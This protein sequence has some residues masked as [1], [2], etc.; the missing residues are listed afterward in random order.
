MD[1]SGYGDNLVF[2][3]GLASAEPYYYISAQLNL[4][5]KSALNKVYYFNKDND[6]SY[7][8]IRDYA[9]Y[10]KLDVNS[11][12]GEVTAYCSP[13]FLYSGNLANLRF[14]IGGVEAPLVTAAQANPDI[15]VWGGLTGNS[16]GP[17]DASEL[18]DG[19]SCYYGSEP[20]GAPKKYL[21]VKL[22][23]TSSPS[24]AS[25]LRGQ[26]YV[27]VKVYPKFG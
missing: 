4:A 16:P 17:L 8:S 2:R 24:S 23:D 1:F 6:F 9:A 14:R 21:A 20:E 22:S 18:E 12:I 11:V 25:I 10:Y 15:D 3:T 5:G 19:Q 27:I 7:L 13:D 26:I